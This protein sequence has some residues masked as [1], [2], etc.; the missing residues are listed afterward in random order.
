MADGNSDIAANTHAEWLA[1]VQPTGLVVAASVLDDLVSAPTR[2]TAVDNAEVLETLEIKDARAK[3]A[4]AYIADAWGFASK[5]LGWEPAFVAGVDGGPPLPD[6]EVVLEAQ[7]VTLR[8]DWVVVAKARDTAGRPRHH[9]RWS[10][11]CGKRV[12]RPA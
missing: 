11:C 7:G 12:R 1:H 8:P 9:S 5:V 2:Q 10:A 6:V 3:D 4:G